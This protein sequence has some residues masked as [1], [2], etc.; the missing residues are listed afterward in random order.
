MTRV[1]LLHTVASLPATFA[2]LL[3]DEVGPVD[4]VHLVDESLLRD[5]VARGMLPGTRSRVTAYAKFAEQSG[6]QA[7]L[8]TCSSIGEAAEHAR[9]EVGIPI[10]RVDEPMAEQAVATGSR[11]GVLATL[12]AT[13]GPT[14]NLLRR[15]A[16]ARG[17]GYE[18]RQ[19]VC[20]GA[21]EALRAGDTD[22]HD[23][24]V[25]DELRRMA[26]RVDVVVLAQASMARVADALPPGD[27]PVPVLRSPRSGV[28]QLRDV[29]ERAAR[30][31]DPGNRR[32]AGGVSGGGDGTG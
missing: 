6:A 21:F 12:S 29:A 3:P 32:A 28:R 17:S 30:Q 10:Y 13:C 1:A 20:E 16:D 31:A 19:S 5:T 26:A 2:A 9:A 23:R 24:I 27:L 4:A 22:R 7:L 14:G 15:K 18:L 25:A 8:V 11:I